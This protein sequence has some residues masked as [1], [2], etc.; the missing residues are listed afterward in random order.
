MPNP[1]TISDIEDRFRTLT[2]TERTNAEAYLEDAWWL[3]TGRIPA[4]E[5]NMAAGTVKVGNVVR[6]VTAMVIR[7]L[8]N[9]EGKLEESIDD[10][11]YRR[12]SLVS[13]GVL[14]VTDAELADL[15]PG[16]GRRT[17]SVRLVAYGE[18]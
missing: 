12:D 13:S 10:Y 6:V 16:S 15:T 7:V 5:A 3:L 2:A 14:S 9:P 11:R 18:L 17:N 1:A 4:L 8:R